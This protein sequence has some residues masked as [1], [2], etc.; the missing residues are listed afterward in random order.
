MNAR[1]LV[2]LAP[3]HPG[4]SDRSYRAR[5]D[6]IA[7]AAIDFHAADARGPVP[8]AD[9][10]EAEHAV[11]R[12]VWAELG[13]RHAD[14]A[15]EAVLGLQDQLGLSRARIP[16]LAEVSARL[17]S[18]TGLRMLPVEG[19]VAPRRFFTTLHEGVF[20]ATQYV[21]HASRPLYTPEPDVIH[22]LVGHAATLAHP[23]L[24]ALNRRFGLAAKLGDARVRARLERVYWFTLE[25]GLVAE[26]G[27]VRAFG[28]GLLSSIAEIE[29]S[30]THGVEHLD[31]DLER[32][33]STDYETSSFQDRLF[34]APSFEQMIEDLDAWLVAELARSAPR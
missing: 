9:Y 27:G 2:H 5:R 15:A 7:Q 20:L 14:L 19:L 12:S 3:D 8:D 25:F 11:W 18:A 6:A 30:Q 32:M 31:W 23:G 26:R 16:Q 1:H 10:V 21:R 4:F 28:A 22:E 17:S 34:V 29:R 13:P 24:A 33:A